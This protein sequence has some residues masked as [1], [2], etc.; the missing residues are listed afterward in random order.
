MPKAL[1]L[2]KLSNKSNLKKPGSS[3]KLK[4]VCRDNHSQDT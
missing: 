4:T 2:L 1:E 3:Q